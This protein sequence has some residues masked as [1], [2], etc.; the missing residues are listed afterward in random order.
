MFAG[1][2]LDGPVYFPAEFLDVVFNPMQVGTQADYLGNGGRGFLYLLV[3][4]SAEP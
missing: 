1:N 3:T 2:I 4:H